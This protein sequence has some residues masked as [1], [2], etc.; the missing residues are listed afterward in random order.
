MAVGTPEQSFA[1]LPQWPLSNVLIYNASGHC[2]D[3]LTDD[4]NTETFCTTLRG[5]QYRSLALSTSTTAVVA[6]DAQV[7]QDLSPHYPNMS[8]IT[9]TLKLNANVS[10][11]NFPMGIALN[12]WGKAGRHPQM[13]SA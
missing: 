10:L 9:D 11:P 12:Y 8:F 2:E 13:P 6:S 1:F 3:P 5:G 4:I 7:P